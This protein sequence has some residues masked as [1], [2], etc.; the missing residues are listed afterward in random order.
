[1]KK[2]IDDI[3]FMGKKVLMRVDF[4]VL[5]K[6]GVIILNKRI[7]V[8]IFIIKKIINEGGK[9][10]L[11]LY[12]GR[13]KSVEDMVKNDLFFVLVELVKLLNKFVLFVDLIRGVELENVINSMY[14]GDVILM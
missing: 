1:M 6:N 12:L 14:N 11:M 3:K 2:S 9:L 13:I 4:N 7:V 8:V 10:I 5:I